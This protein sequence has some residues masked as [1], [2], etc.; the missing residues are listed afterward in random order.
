[1]KQPTV[2][3]GYAKA[4]FDFAVRQG[5]S[6]A[7]LQSRS[8]LDAAVLGDPDNRVALQVY[9]DLTAAAKDLCNDPA[10][11]L[12]LGAA[13][14]FTEISVVGLIC[15]AADTMGEA[16]AELNR[17]GR[18][19]A[20]LDV[21]GSDE[22]FQVQQRD[23]GLWLV[24]TRADPNSFPEMTEET[25]SRFI[26]ETARNFPGHKLAR[27]V[28]VTHARPAHGDAY[29]RVMQAPVVFG[30]DRNAIEID[31]SW[32][33]MPT[34]RANAYAFGVLSERAEKLL[35][36]L[37]SSGTVRGRVE[38]LLIPILHKGDATMES[39]SA[40]LG[41]SRQSLYRRLK[42]EDISFEALH[43]DLRHR[44]AV[45]FLNARKVSVNETAYLVGFS[46]PSSFS[47]AFKRWTGESPGSWKR[48]YPNAP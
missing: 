20:E 21:P 24:D 10:L 28:H 44:M 46:D 31:A 40:Q 1:V 12:H 6:A 29:E 3:A 48:A 37:Q 13:Q 36:E 15:Y 27:Q 18:L 7:E 16:L 11:P 19:V 14:N 30:S 45:H 4:L 26:C 17:F 5:A 32:L 39:V 22:R 41:M 34:N 9:V 25:W 35:E 47:R 23:G 2:S 42:D 43:D 33:T 8:G 38:R